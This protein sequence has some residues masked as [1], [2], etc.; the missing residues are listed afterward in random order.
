MAKT[1]PSTR[2]TLLLGALVVGG[3]VCVLLTT[4][5]RGDL[6]IAH[7]SCGTAGCH[8]QEVLQNRKSMMAHG[9]MLWGA[10]LY[11]NGAVPNKWARYGESYSMNGSPQRMQTVPPPSEDDIRRKGVVPFLDPLPRFEITQPGNI[12][13]ISERGGKARPDTGIPNTR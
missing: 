7:L 4:R 1:L 2:S 12:L 3:I 11:N 5:T 10:A 8:G 9:C 6:R 13:R